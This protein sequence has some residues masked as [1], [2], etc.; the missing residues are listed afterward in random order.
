[1]EEA[2]ETALMKASAAARC[3]LV[4]EETLVIGKGIARGKEG[5][6]LCWRAGQGVTDP[7]QRNHIARVHAR[8][9]KHHSKIPRSNGRGSCS[10]DECNDGEV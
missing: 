6:Y 2:L 1:M 3:G 8:G 7:C 5:V 4:S 9:H 10:N